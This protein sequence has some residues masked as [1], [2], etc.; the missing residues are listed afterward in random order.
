MKAALVL[1]F[2]V[3]LAGCERQA[4]QTQA[5]GVDFQVDRLFTID[6]CTVYRFKDAGSSRYFTNCSGSTQWDESHQCG[7]SRCTR[8]QGISGATP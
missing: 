4:E 3:L 1:F 8:P 5:A 6:D 2:V 7:K